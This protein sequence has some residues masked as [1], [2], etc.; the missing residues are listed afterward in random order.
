MALPARLR[1]ATPT[2][3][4]RKPPH[5][6]ARSPN[7]PKIRLRYVRYVEPLPKRFSNGRLTTLAAQESQATYEDDVNLLL[8]TEVEVG[9]YW[10]IIEQN[11]CRS[12]RCMERGDTGV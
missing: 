5:A 3:F 8:L 11:A 6:H 9:E 10:A 1:H 2:R 7:S 4:A 12:R